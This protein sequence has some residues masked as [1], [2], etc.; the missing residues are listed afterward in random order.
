MFLHGII[1]ALYQQ[2]D[3]IITVHNQYWIRS[4]AGDRVRARAR[5]RAKAS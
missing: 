5:V 2:D 1:Q 4:S 3:I